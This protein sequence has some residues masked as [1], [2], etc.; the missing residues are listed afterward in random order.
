MTDV[1]WRM[2]LW[3]DFCHCVYITEL[4]YT[5]GIRYCDVTSSE[6]IL[7]DFGC[8]CGPQ[9]TRTSSHSMWPSFCKSVIEVSGG[10]T[11]SHTTPGQAYILDAGNQAGRDAGKKRTLHTSG[12]SSFFSFNKYLEYP[13]PI[14]EI[15]AERLT[16]EVA[17]INNSGFPLF[18]EFLNCLIR[19]DV[20]YLYLLVIH[21]PSGHPHWKFLRETIPLRFMLSGK[22]SL[23][24]FGIPN[25]SDSL[26]T[27]GIKSRCVD[28][29]EM[30]GYYPDGQTEAKDE[31]TLKKSDRKLRRSVF[32]PHWP[33]PCIFSV[34]R[35]Q[36]NLLCILINLRFPAPSPV[37]LQPNES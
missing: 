8:I 9:L 17:Q 18:S 21:S 30:T 29:H 3:V 26:L 11:Q 31:A 10:S 12:C 19:A 22:S 35:N 15:A 16:N 20:A 36:R 24:I 7:W 13:A 23:A 37:P 28:R 2:C 14:T 32:R 6:A 5:K 27:M 4:I 1:F 33:K 34:L 25:L